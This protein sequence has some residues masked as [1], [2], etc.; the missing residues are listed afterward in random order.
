MVTR[1]SIGQDSG[2]PDDGLM[3][4]KVHLYKMLERHCQASY[5]AA[6]DEFALVLRVSG[7]FQDFGPEAIERLR[8]SRT[9]RY[10][11][12]DIVVPEHVWRHKDERT[13]KEYLADRVR[14]ALAVCV[15]RL[16]RDKEPVDE[17]TL[18]RDVDE[19]IGAFLAA[20]TPRTPWK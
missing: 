4:P 10:I 15:A 11:S 6:I 7:A 16:K 18:F 17:A 9:G 20:T 5:C 8:R 2:G 3:W 19:A 14:A 13:L 1:I 12:V